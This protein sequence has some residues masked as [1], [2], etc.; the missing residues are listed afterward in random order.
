MD[1]S[2]ILVSACE[3]ANA[4][5]AKILGV[6]ADQHAALSITEFVEIF[7]ENWEFVVATEALAKRMIASL[8]GVTATQA[9]LHMPNLLKADVQART[10]LI[11]YHGARLTKSAKAVEEEQWA[12]IDVPASVQHT[13]DLLIS[14]ATEDSPECLIPPGPSTVS[15]GN[16]DAAPTKQLNIEDRGFFIVKATSETLV[17]LADYLKIVI[18]LELVVMD[19]MSRIIEF[20]KVCRVCTAAVPV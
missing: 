15:N 4:R 6:R 3:L 2:D 12:Q 13:V 11:A 1:L 8:R 10:F 16:A 9:S 5:A 7:K 14:S 17:L 18:N 19:V 20:L